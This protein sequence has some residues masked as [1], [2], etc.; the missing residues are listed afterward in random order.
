MSLGSCDI[1]VFTTV[2]WEK[3][4]IKAEYNNIIK[5]KTWTKNGILQTKLKSIKR[6]KIKLKMI[7]QA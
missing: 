5:N 2:Q 3:I 7:W 6:D 4:K 1:Y